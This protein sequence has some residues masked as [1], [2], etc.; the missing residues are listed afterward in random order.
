[1]TLHS[2]KRGNIDFCGVIA[3]LKDGKRVRRLS[4]DKDVYIFRQVPSEISSDVVPKMTSLPQPVK[5]ALME[6]FKDESKQ[7]DSIYYNDQIAK[8]GES[9]LI[10]GWSPL[11]EDIFAIDWVILD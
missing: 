8:V 3:A 2:T 11:T 4:W 7:I 5:D 9:N 6:S 1:M 10:T